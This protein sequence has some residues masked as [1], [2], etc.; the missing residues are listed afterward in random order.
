MLKIAQDRLKSIIDPITRSPSFSTANLVVLGGILINKGEEGEDAFQPVTFEVSGVDYFDDFQ[1][2]L[3]LVKAEA[4]AD[5][6]L[7]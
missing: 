7:A 1:R 6:T 4:T 3:K 2:A 5:A